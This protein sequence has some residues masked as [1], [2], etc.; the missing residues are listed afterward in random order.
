VSGRSWPEQQ[1]WICAIRV[2]DGQRV[3]FG[4]DEHV[5]LSTALASSC[6]V[7]GYFK[8]VQIDGDRFVDGVVHSPTNADVLRDRPMDLIL[9]VSPMSGPGWPVGPYALARRHAA[10]LASPEVAALRRSGTPVLTF[11]PGHREQQV[12]STDV[13]SG[14]RLQEIVQESFLAAGKYAAERDLRPLLCSRV[15]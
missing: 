9:V 12:M 5:L 10:W 2:S 13:W 11:R 7:P 15:S 1:L 8:P 4:R 3:V 6:A 14:D